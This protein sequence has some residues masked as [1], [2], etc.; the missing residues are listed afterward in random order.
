MVYGPNL[1]NASSRPPILTSSRKVV[2]L[3][4]AANSRRFFAAGRSP[5]EFDSFRLNWNCSLRTSI[6]QN[7]IVEHVD[8]SVRSE[9]EVVA[10][11][12]SLDAHAL[13][14]ALQAEPV[15][16]ESAHAVLVD[17]RGSAQRMDEHVVLQESCEK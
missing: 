9:S 2:N 11:T 7:D 8:Q 15:A 6:R 13:R 17:D 4:D 10:Q 14:V 12:G 5:N 3:S 16:G 1:E